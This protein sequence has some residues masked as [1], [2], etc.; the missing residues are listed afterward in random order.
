MG[1]K[2]AVHRLALSALHGRAEVL[3]PA[4]PGQVRDP[5]LKAAVEN[6]QAVL[7]PQGQ[8]QGLLHEKAGARGATEGRGGLERRGP[9]GV[10]GD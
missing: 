3:P 6:Q 9:K 4:F 8:C 10:A 1:R 2:G 7:V 5:L